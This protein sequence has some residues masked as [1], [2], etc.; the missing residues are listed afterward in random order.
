VQHESEPRWDETAEQG[1]LGAAM[2]NPRVL[3]N[4]DIKA[5][6]FYRPA[7][8]QLWQ[9]ISSEVRAG[10]PASPMV[11]AQRLLTNPITGMEPAYLHEC[12]SAAPVRSAVHH[13]V[14][15]VTGL[16]RLRRMEEVGRQLIQQSQTAAWDEA[17]AVLDKGRSVLDATV[18]QAS[19]VKLRSFAQALESAV[20][21]W[22]QPRKRGQPTG[23]A[24]LDDKLNGGWQP[25]QLTVIGARPAVG[26]SV[27]ASCAAVAGS[28]Y[29]LM[30]FSLE[31]SE[32]E[33]IGRMTA[34]AEGIPLS[35]I[36]A[37]Q[38]TDADWSRIS[39]L[40]HRSQNW[41]AF[42]D[43]RSVISMAQIKAAVRTATRR[44]PIPLVI[45]D[46]AQL[47]KAADRSEQRERQV[48]R[49]LEDCKHL[50]KEFNTHVIALAQVNRGSTARDDKRPT[51]SD[52]RESGGIEAHADNIILLHRDD[53]E[54]EGEIELILAKNRHGETG[55][56]RLAWRP[57]FASANSMNHHPDDYRYGMEQAS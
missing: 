20:E 51:M 1:I 23:W 44:G 11:V 25:S 36:T 31:M 4:I 5:E 27:I 56:I 8:E 12:M 9:I 13:S 10:R 39:R 42:I 49:I 19:G 21:R 18:A 34:S 28:S 57:A 29:G 15:I 14:A 52:L 7:H 47:V 37:S 16:A 43:E 45:I 50:A 41:R 33:V 48:S 40:A 2:M 17:E 24:E 55:A 53:H 3:D 46:Y 30:F 6:D 54:M 32:E 35:N 38:L 22:S 26:K